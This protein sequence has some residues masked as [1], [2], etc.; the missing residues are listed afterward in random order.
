[1]A[2]ASE[3]PC[4]LVELR[5]DALPPSITVQDIMAHRPAKPVLVTI[6]CESE[7]GKRYISEAERMDMAKQLLPFAAALDWELSRLESAADLVHAAHDAGVAVIA[8]AHDFQRTPHW[9]SL[10][11]RT[12][13]AR[14]QGADLVKFAFQL[15]SGDDLLMGVRLLRAMREPL[16]IMGMGPLGPVS[17]LLYAQHGSRLVYGYL[18]STPTAHGQW[19]AALFRQTLAALTPAE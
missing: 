16:A 14:A 10:F 4:D 2:Y 5:V 15:N 8:S 6:R 9:Q 13:E 7:G 17:R 19:P 18:G 11:A 12:N 3:L 1:M